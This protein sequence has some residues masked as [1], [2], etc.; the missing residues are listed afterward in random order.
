[1]G[2]DNLCGGGGGRVEIP[3]VPPTSTIVPMRRQIAAKEE[4][5]LKIEIASSLR[6][7]Q[8]QLWDGGVG[9]Y[10]S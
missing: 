4:R 8:R 5:L 3:L 10:H 9:H 6:S 7:S 2:I 1:M